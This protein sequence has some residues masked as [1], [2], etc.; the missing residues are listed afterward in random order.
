MARLQ[1][2]IRLSAPL[3]AGTANMTK[4]GFII[5]LAVAMAGCSPPSEPSNS[6]ALNE[7]AD[8]QT[9]EPDAIA[10]RMI[11]TRY[12]DHIANKRYADAYRLWGNNGADTRGSLDQFARSFGSFERYDVTVGEP[13]E[14]KTSAGQ[15]YISVAA[16]ARVKLRTANTMSDRSGTVMLRRPASPETASSSTPLTVNGPVGAAGSKSETGQWRIWGVDIRAR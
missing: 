2:Q 8:R 1:V 14:I 7:T 4:Q 16:S 11:V 9:P 6:A 12:F 15:D 5:M 13:T 10:A 3:T